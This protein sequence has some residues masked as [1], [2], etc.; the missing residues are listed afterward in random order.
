MR[1]PDRSFWREEWKNAP[2][3][4]D[5]RLR[6]DFAGAHAGVDLLSY[7]VPEQQTG[8]FM[9]GSPFEQYATGPKTAL[10]AVSAPLVAVSRGAVC[11]GGEKTW[12][13]CP[14]TDGALDLVILELGARP[15]PVDGQ[16]PV[17][18]APLTFA[19]TAPAQP[20]ELIVRDLQTSWVEGEVR[21][22]GSSNG[23]D[24]EPIGELLL[25]PRDPIYDPD[26]DPTAGFPAYEYF[27]QGSRWMRVPLTPLQ[28]P[29]T[30]LRIEGLYGF[31]A[32]EL[33]F[34]E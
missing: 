12:A 4:V 10:P 18:P 22:M 31:A 2:L 29:L 9:S 5:A 1:P 8:P 32:R 21:V 33:S 34:F 28:Q 25:G 16:E 13:P 23:V 15:E 30:H 19:L 27:N 7:I 11:T 17:V 6:E 24:F 3:K 14:L 20:T 26:W